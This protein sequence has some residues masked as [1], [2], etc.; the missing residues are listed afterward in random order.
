M[1]K[2]SVGKKML[3]NQ[4]LSKFAFNTW[5]FDSRKFAWAPDL[6][7]HGE[8]QLEAHP[9]TGH[10]LRMRLHAKA[11]IWEASLLS[12]HGPRRV[13]GLL[14]HLAYSIP[15]RSQRRSPF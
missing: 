2:E 1:D 3:L 4:A 9:D 6:V 13:E 15:N 8:V 14:G 7:D 10:A 12:T 5:I 11:P